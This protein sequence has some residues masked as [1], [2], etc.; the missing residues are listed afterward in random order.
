MADLIVKT[1]REAGATRVRL[2][3]PNGRSFSDLNTPSDDQMILRDAAFGDYGAIVQPLGKSP[4]YFQFTFGPQSGAIEL[5]TGSPSTSTAIAST[6]ST[7][8]GPLIGKP[9]DLGAS[10]SYFSSPS[11]VMN[12]DVVDP[13][14]FLGPKPILRTLEQVPAPFSGEAAQYGQEPDVGLPAELGGGIAPSRPT[15]RPR[16]AALLWNDAI[17]VGLSED[18]LPFDPGGWRPYTGVAPHI[19]REGGRTILI[20]ERCGQSL[21]PAELARL[22]VSAKLS[23]GAIYR[24]LIPLFQG[25]VRI[26]LQRRDDGSREIDIGVS[27]LDV[28]QLALSQA[29]GAGF[30]SEASVIL[31]QF[32]ARHD[33]ASYISDDVPADPWTALLGLLV[34][35]RFSRLA[36]AQRTVITDLAQRYGW[37]T[38]ALILQARDLISPADNGSLGFDESRKRALRALK[39]ARRVGAPYYSYANSLASDI[40]A[41]LASRPDDDPSASAPGEFEQD[42][43]TERGRWQAFIRWQGQAGAFFTWRTHQRFGLSTAFDP[44]YTAALPL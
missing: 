39:R 15:R 26:S 27:P 2:V 9:T 11:D 44:R 36:E 4:Q 12:S 43:A 22:R 5:G 42:V 25:G 29:L 18:S 33:L 30:G 3:A 13:L 35:T 6:A 10:P 28:D 14:F 24:V 23:G 1:P 7:R 21:P 31:D 20:F 34:G 17:A 37:I 32:M 40:L 8:P 41:A 38:D 19:E 16:K